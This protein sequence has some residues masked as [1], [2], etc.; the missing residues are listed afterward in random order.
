MASGPFRSTDRSTFGSILPEAL[1]H[2]QDIKLENTFFGEPI[3]TSS[4]GRVC[5]ADF[6]VSSILTPTGPEN[7]ASLQDEGTQI[8]IAPE[9]RVSDMARGRF[10]EPFIPKHY[11]NRRTV[12]GS[13]RIT[14]SVNAWPIGAM[15]WVLTTGRDISELDRIVLNI[16]ERAYWAYKSHTILP[17][18]TGADPEYSPELLEL[19]RDC[20]K[21]NPTTR[22]CPAELRRR[23]EGGMDWR[24]QFEIEQ[25][26]RD[27]DL[28]GRPLTLYCKANEIQSQPLGDANY[29]LD[30]VFWRRVIDDQIWL[31]PEWDHCGLPTPLMTGRRLSTGPITFA[32]ILKT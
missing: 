13:H 5:I 22:P 2:H 12:I 18:R 29:I 19:I 21:L 28:I 4:Y 31:P 11:T 27:P 25:F 16:D 10:D 20:L 14:P 3:G 32:R 8:W 1:L 6:G 26:M 7:K 9:C 24:M 23:A 17:I 30:G 15:M